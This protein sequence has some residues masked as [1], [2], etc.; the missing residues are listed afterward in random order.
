MPEAD[1]RSEEGTPAP[2]DTTL[3]PPTPR[4]GPARTRSVGPASNVGETLEPHR[5][6]VWPPE[7]TS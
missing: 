6:L 5:S 7:R 2:A 1:Y 4:L 3:P